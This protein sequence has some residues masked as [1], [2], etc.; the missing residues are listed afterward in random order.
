MRKFAV[1]VMSE[2]AAAQEAALMRASAKARQ[3]R[4]VIYTGSPDHDGSTR[5]EPSMCDQSTLR[6]E[7]S[8]KMKRRATAAPC[9]HG[10]RRHRLR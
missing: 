3:R 7:I 2:L 6:I 9:Q 5:N 10:F 1:W 4:H 8:A